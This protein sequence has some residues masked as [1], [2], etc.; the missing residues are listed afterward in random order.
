MAF[1]PLALAVW[2]AIGAA[3]SE[4]RQQY[5]ADLSVAPHA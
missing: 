5:I 1:G 4:F 3:D 2:L